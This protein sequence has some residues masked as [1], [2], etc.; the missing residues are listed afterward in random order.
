MKLHLAGLVCGPELPPPL[1]VFAGEK[2]KTGAKPSVTQT[3]GGREITWV[4]VEA[5][6]GENADNKRASFPTNF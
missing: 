5:I 6:E 2:V 3:I 1:Q 4:F